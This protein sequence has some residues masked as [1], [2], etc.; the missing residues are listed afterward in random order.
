M[1]IGYIGLGIMG[2]PMAENLLKAGHMLLVS[3]RTVS[4]CNPLVAQGA[5]ACANPALVAKACE[6]VF[7][8]V[9]DTPDVEQVLFGEEGVAAGAPEGLI[10]VDN[11]TISA[12]RTREFSERLREQGVYYLDAPVSGG[13]VGARK[14]TLSIMVGG[15]AEV[16]EKC[17]PL[18]EILGSKVTH[19][20]PVGAG[21]T[22]KAIN[23]LFG[24]LHMVA[25]CEGITLARKAGLDPA[26]VVEVISAGA[27][28]SWA[29]SNLGPKIVA[30]DTAPGFMIDLLYKD[31][32]YTMEL[33]QDT[34]Q[35]LVGAGLAQQ[36]FAAAQHMDLGREG[37]QALYKVIE[38]LGKDRA[39]SLWLGGLPGSDD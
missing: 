18:L 39:V 37:T 6:V 33:G 30:G 15:E 28:G 11:S 31:L 14:G 19:V 32:K 8:N 20:G 25:C 9:T 5:L 29:L 24:A 21:Q 4:K 38:S 3:N 36:L 13:D 2:L 34:D 22:C 7:L 10:V 1:N 27:S 26:T 35:P 23:Q 12:A 17:L 16:F